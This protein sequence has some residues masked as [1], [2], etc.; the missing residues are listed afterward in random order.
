VKITLQITFSIKEKF[1][2]TV[3]TWDTASKKLRMTMAGFVFFM[4]LCSIVLSLFPVG[5]AAMQV[6]PQ[7]RVNNNNK[8]IQIISAGKV[9]QINF[10]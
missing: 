7:Y 5:Q 2:E 1:W 9:I 8:Y 10:V 3:P 4:A 6:Q